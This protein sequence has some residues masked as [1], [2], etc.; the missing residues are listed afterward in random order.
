[1]IE[2]KLVANYPQDL[3]L[4]LTP[5]SRKQY[6]G[7]YDEYLSQFYSEEHLF[8]IVDYIVDHLHELLIKP[9]VK[10]KGYSWGIDVV[11]A[12]KKAL[13]NGNHYLL[14]TQ[15]YDIFMSSYIE[16]KLKPENSALDRY[17][18]LFLILESFAQQKAC[19]KID[20]KL[21]EIW[22]NFPKEELINAVIYP[23]EQVY[24]FDES[25]A[26]L[27]INHEGK[28]PELYYES[29]GYLETL[30]V[31]LEILKQL[32]KTQIGKRE[33]IE[34]TLTFLKIA[35]D[36][37]EYF[38]FENKTR[39]SSYI[40][41]LYGVI[42]DYIPTELIGLFQ[43]FIELYLD[44]GQTLFTIK[45]NKTQVKTFIK[46]YNKCFDW[47]IANEF[48]MPLET[49][50]SNIYFTTEE[51]KY[52][53]IVK[54]VHQRLFKISP[55]KANKVTDGHIH[56]NLLFSNKEYEMIVDFYTQGYL[57]DADHYSFE[58][59]YSLYEMSYYEAAK[60]MYLKLVE[61][62][63]APASVYNN[64]GLLYNDIE[65]NDN[66]AIEYYKLAID[67]GSEKAKENLA[68]LEK[69]IQKR[70]ER[71]RQIKEDYF[72]STNKYHK[73]VLF[74]LYKWGNRPFTI[75]E[76]AMATKQ[77]FSYTE[78]NIT[79]LIHLGMLEVHQDHYKIDPTV[80]KLVAEFID[81]KLER[82]IIQ[83]DRSNI[84]RPIFFHESEIN[85][86]R[87]L[88]ELFPQQF[89]FPNISLK[90]IMDVEKLRENL[91]SEQLNYLFMAHVDFAIISTSSY[92]PIL[93][94]EKDS[95]YH[96]SVHSLKKDEMKNSIFK[97]SGIP[98]I[99]IR[100]NKGMTAEK[101]KQEIR[102]ATK[103]MLILSQKD[104]ERDLNIL[105]EIDLRNFGISLHSDID[106]DVLQGLW[107]EIVGE[108]VSKKSRII[109]L[110]NGNQL[111]V[112]VASELETLI[113]FS[114][115]QIETKLKSAIPQ[116]K[117]LF[118]TYH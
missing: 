16:W 107:D 73:K 45:M 84:S 12:L 93:A 51:D 61:A 82:Q 109:D 115:E 75:E 10:E 76:L 58:I 80:E 70:T 114:R 86:Y 97:L 24:L 60:E 31:Y 28:N 40:E 7:D 62:G 99:R 89:V 54:N 92:I 63:N 100:F 112:S 25:D 50:W 65:N 88:L 110:N 81:P 46:Q 117:E 47:C 83:A 98:L 48:Y 95:T 102:N 78:K 79:D 74:T 56:L 64:L 104:S 96:D 26:H 13:V 35:Y 43:F 37:S 17:D 116:M 5:I 103:E 111:H 105:D 69:E 23:V 90:T 19:G 42:D 41:E 3:I 55:N 21:L 106:L 9:E 44:E 38:L 52:Y 108:G 72:K 91:S 39:I 53:D 113:D 18:I 71:S 1:M 8:P 59:A 57:T 11:Y 27:Y 101:L 30:D 85:L 14:A 22:N 87:V 66:K 67:H 32:D 4:M 20:E 77:S 33:Y 15:K 118:I 6:D 2:T 49:I 94:I 36:T 68:I 34:H 29:P